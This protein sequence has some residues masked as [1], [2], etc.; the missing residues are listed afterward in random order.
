MISRLLLFIVLFAYLGCSGVDEK[1]VDLRKQA[2]TAYDA[3]EKA[4]ASKSF[5][6]A[7]DQYALA[8]QGGLYADFI[9]PAKIKLA[10]STAESGDIETAFKMISEMEQ[11]AENKA[12]VLA[13]RSH[14]LAKQGK[15]AESQAVWAQA[16][17]YNRNV[18]KFGN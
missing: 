16:I 11:G 1:L 18:K 6:E 9:E 15:A 7:K 17:R 2:S 4:F 14:I 10:V 8:L 5:A 12:D 13:A 3:A